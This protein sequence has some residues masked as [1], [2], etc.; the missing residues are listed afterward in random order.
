MM[1][2]F[3]LKPSSAMMSTVC[4]CSQYSR[5]FEHLATGKVCSCSKLCIHTPCVKMGGHGLDWLHWGCMEP[6]VLNTTYCNKTKRM[7]GKQSHNPLDAVSLKLIA[8]ALVLHLWSHGASSR[9]W[10][11]WWWERPTF[12]QVKEQFSKQGISRKHTEQASL[13]I[14]TRPATTQVQ[15]HQKQEAH[16]LRMKPN[17]LYTWCVSVLEKLWMFSAGW[18]NSSVLLKE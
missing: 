1:T 15:L 13:E 11:V 4:P 5:Y 14:L 6:S 12:S 2:G 8:L 3:L 7:K 10:R 18:G 9:C 17:K 16:K